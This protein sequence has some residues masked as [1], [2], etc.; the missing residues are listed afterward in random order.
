MSKCLVILTFNETK[1]F[2]DGEE[3]QERQHLGLAI[4]IWVGHKD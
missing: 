1:N 4:D 2:C 3:Y